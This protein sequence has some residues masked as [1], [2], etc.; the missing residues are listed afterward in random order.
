MSKQRGGRVSAVDQVREQFDQWQRGEIE[1]Y[2]FY[3]ATL[4]YRV[5]TVA[6]ATGIDREVIQDR[7]RYM[8]QLAVD[9]S[10]PM[11]IVRDESYGALVVD[12][13]V[14]ARTSHKTL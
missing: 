6:E 14:V 8:R 2:E 5:S 11:G 12:D 7:R 3:V 10:K 13:T 1:K 9:A 4:G